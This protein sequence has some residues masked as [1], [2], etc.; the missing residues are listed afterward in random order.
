M[1]ISAESLME[2]EKLREHLQM[3]I[4]QKDDIVDAEILNV[5]RTLDVLLNEYYRNQE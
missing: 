1:T 4:E 2:V 5:S 3:L